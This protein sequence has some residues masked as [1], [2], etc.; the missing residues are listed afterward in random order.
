MLAQI[1]ARFA[2]SGLAVRRM[3][4]G[5]SNDGVVGKAKARGPA[6]RARPPPPHK[7]SL[8][9]LLLPP[10]FL[11]FPHAYLSPMN[12]KQ[13]RGAA[14]QATS[15]LS[16]SFA[17]GAA[18]E[19]RSTRRV[20]IETRGEEGREPHAHPCL[21]PSLQPRTNARSTNPRSTTTTNTDDR[22]RCP[23][24]GPRRGD[25][26]RQ[27][28][29]HPRRGGERSGRAAAAAQPSPVPSSSR[30]KNNTPRARAVIKPNHTPTCTHTQPNP[31]PR[32]TNKN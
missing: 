5:A 29:L 17:S 30:E 16:R 23:H 32:N 19:V 31:P 4:D 12:N 24:V 10:P 22:A 26:A 8:T 2:L 1:A 14:V 18:G 27:G 11:F 13:A 7:P 15:A 20:G 28:R 3:L 9:F 6:A 21:V 25:G